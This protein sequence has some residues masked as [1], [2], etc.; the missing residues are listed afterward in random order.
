MPRVAP[1]DLIDWS[2][3]LCCNNWRTPAAR[4]APARVVADPRTVPLSQ[5][6]HPTQCEGQE[7]VGRL[8]LW[9]VCV[10][11]PGGKMG[12]GKKGKRGRGQKKKKPFNPLMAMIKQTVADNAAKVDDDEGGYTYKSKRDTALNA[13]RIAREKL[14]RKEAQDRA[15]AVR[16]GFV[17]GVPVWVWMWRRGV[18]W[19]CWHASCHLTCGPCQSVDAFGRWNARDNVKSRHAQTS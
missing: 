16:V 10:W 2:D 9:G 19:W 6:V 12:K 8:G 7:T 14:A 5:C 1:V 15:T 4:S 11:L 13:Q 3:R 17:G 18:L